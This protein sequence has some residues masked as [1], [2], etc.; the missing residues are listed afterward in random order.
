DAVRGGEVAVAHDVS[1]GGLACTVAECAIAGGV[2]ARVELEEGDDG[3]AALFGE[4]TGRFVVAGSAEAI[5]RIVDEAGGKG[6]PAAVIGAAGGDVIE[7][8]VGETAVELALDRA[9]GA[10]ES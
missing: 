5:A 7:I 2:G 10:W 6:V 1:D 4:G 3:K 9:V 8:V